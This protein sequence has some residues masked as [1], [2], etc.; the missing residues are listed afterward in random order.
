MYVRLEFRSSKFPFNELPFH[1]VSKF[2][3]VDGLYIRKGSKKLDL[4]FTSYKTADSIKF[5]RFSFEKGFN[6][7]SR[8][9]GIKF[10]H[11]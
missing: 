3:P 4:N 9:F 2:S 11:K 7:P 5:L 10:S 1:F 6:K 8:I